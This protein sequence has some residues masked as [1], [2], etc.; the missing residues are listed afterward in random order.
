[1]GFITH[2]VNKYPYT[3]FHELN[4]DFLLNKY[5]EIVDTVNQIQSWISQHEIDY[6]DAIR[7][8]TAVEN[9]IDTFEA[10]INARFAQ[11]QAENEAHFE[12]QDKKL[13][14]AIKAQDERVSQAIA[15]MRAEVEQA[16]A[17]MIADFEA[18]KTEILAEI[19]ALKIEVEQAII[20]LNNRIETNNQFL[21]HYIENRL[22][23]FIHDL[24][25]IDEMDVYNPIKATMTPIQE[26]INDLYDFARFYGLT[27]LQY[28][29]LGLTASE[30]DAYELT[31]MNYDQ[32]GYILLGY[33]DPL[34]YMLS[35]FTGEYVPIKDVIM[36]LANLHIGNNALTASEYDALELEAE[37]Y[38]NEDIEAFNYDWFGKQILI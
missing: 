30:Y 3:D 2:F 7:R 5:Q 10:Q 35:P 20:Q 11:M 12:A 33:P 15:G 36:D 14:D 32:M 9:E 6:E 27:A 26:A 34:W 19:R 28:D 1:M 31:A 18:I 37:S 13:D 22:D 16:I 8:L 23:Q 4:L 38:D 17:Q 29:S 21:F 24:P 25:S